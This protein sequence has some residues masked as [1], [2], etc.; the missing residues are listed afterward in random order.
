MLEEIC[1][2]ITLLKQPEGWHDRST[3]THSLGP[4]MSQHNKWKISFTNSKEYGCVYI[5]R[6]SCIL[7]IC[8]LRYREQNRGSKLLN[9][10]WRLEGSQHCFVVL[11]LLLFLC[12]LEVIVLNDHDVNITWHD[13]LTQLTI[14]EAVIFT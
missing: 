5:Q 4:T 2:M 6:K 1:V 11:F 9:S 3:N 12:W 7:H 13:V 8:Y 14:L 10:Q